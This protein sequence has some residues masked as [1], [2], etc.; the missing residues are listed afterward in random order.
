MTKI[1]AALASLIAISLVLWTN[2]EGDVRGDQPGKQDGQTAKFS[3]LLSC[4]PCHQRPI[5]EYKKQGVTKFVAL[6]ES[7][8][9][10][11]QDKHR[12]AYE[13]VDPKKSKNE[14]SRKMCKK[15]GID[16]AKFDQAQQCLSCHSN[17][18][19]GNASPPPYFNLGVGCESCHGASR[20]WFRDHIV[21]GWRKLTPEEKAKKGMVDVRNPIARAQQCYSCH[22]GSAKEGKVLTHEMYA[23]GHPPL[24]SIEIETFSSRMPAH[25]RHFDAKPDFTFRKEYEAAN[26]IRP[27]EL[28]RTR[29][30]IIGALVALRESIQLVSDQ[31]RSKESWPQLASFDCY[32]CHHDLRYPSWRQK[33]GYKGRPGR[34]QMRYWTG[35]LIHLAVDL[36]AGGDNAKGKELDREFKAA[37]AAIHSSLDRKPFGERPVLQSACEKVVKWAN[38]LL[39][40]CE[41]QTVNQMTVKR[42]LRLLYDV[43][44]N[45]RDILDYD[46]ARQRLWAFQQIYSDLKPKPPTDIAI[47]KRLKQ[48]TQSFQL[49]LP[50]GQKKKILDNLPAVM[51]SLNEFDPVKLSHEFAELGKLLRP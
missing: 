26:R 39:A 30:V 51:K 5:E 9:W 27:N 48:L 34:P 17:W 2:G 45:G 10:A 31:S 41:S 18:I 28:N 25:W 23:A 8:V 46:S 19:K 50:A 38:G 21:P 49:E 36:A 37:M 35:S 24:P 44:A 13:L 47:Q 12:L 4:V 14:L 40:K 3:G 22:I 20:D 42:A 11:K 6:T 32:A 15:L 33:R 29:S 7:L 43:K 16:P 1:F